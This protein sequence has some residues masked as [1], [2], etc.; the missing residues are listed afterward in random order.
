MEPEPEFFQ[1]F[2]IQLK[3][4]PPDG[5]GSTTLAINK[6]EMGIRFEHISNKYPDP[7]A[8]NFYGLQEPDSG[9][10]YLS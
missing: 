8:G 9:L 4:V 6:F 3:S 1:W 10:T 5:S 7:D 2:R